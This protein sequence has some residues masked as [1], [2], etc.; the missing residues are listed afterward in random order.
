MATEAASGIIA[1]YAAAWD[2]HDEGKRRAL[3]ERSWARDGA[4]CDPTALVE[5]REAPIAHIG[6]FHERMP[7]ARIAPTTGVD[8]HGGH[9]R[10]GWR[11]LGPQ[12][13]VALEGM[14]FGE[15]GDDGRPK[16]IV[17]FFGPFPP[18]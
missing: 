12:A 2:A 8:A 17:G 3:L 1:S 10:F 15:L 18:A 11:M 9:L 6:G 5:G 13:T 16:R 14:D 7:G 4:C